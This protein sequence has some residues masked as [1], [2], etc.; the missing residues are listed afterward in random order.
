ML[1]N[2]NLD[3]D[4]DK[5]LGDLRF[6]EDYSV[7]NNVELTYYLGGDREH[8]VAQRQDN[9]LY[10]DNETDSVQFD[11]SFPPEILIEKKEDGTYL[12]SNC[13]KPVFFEPLVSW[14]ENQ[15]TESVVFGW[16]PHPWLS[17]N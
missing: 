8:F 5:L 12:C 13:P 2:R 6:T 17:K 7:F 1:R 4:N 14:I 11:L 16:A 15:L 9:G 3:N 10:P